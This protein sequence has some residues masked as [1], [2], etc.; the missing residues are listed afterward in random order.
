MKTGRQVCVP[1]Q[2]F[3]R[4]SWVALFSPLPSLYFCYLE[5]NV[6]WADIPFSSWS[7]LD[8][9]LAMTER[10]T[11]RNRPNPSRVCL[12]LHS[13]AT[14]VWFLLHAVTFNLADTVHLQPDLH[15]WRDFLSVHISVSNFYLKYSLSSHS[16]DGK[17]NY[18][19]CHLLFYDP[20]QLHLYTLSIA[21]FIL[22]IN[23]S[24]DRPR[25]SSSLWECLI[26]HILG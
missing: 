13:T 4:L 21:S 3:K 2:L 20:S 14:V 8:G 10:M 9:F 17:T 16:L 26:L 1:G 25:K 5:W 15:P 24:S 7:K 18:L 23:T 22:S 19:G 12:P 11:N 6:I